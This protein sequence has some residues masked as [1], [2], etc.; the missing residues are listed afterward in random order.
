MK[1]LPS[2][3][4][5]SLNRRRL[6]SFLFWDRDFVRVHNDQFLFSVFFGNSFVVFFGFSSILFFENKNR[7]KKRPKHAATTAT[8]A[9]TSASLR[10]LTSFVLSCCLLQSLAA[11]NSSWTTTRSRL[12]K[13]LPSWRKNFFPNF[14]SSSRMRVWAKERTERSCPKKA[15]RNI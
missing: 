4:W 15:L 2:Y 6:S 10:L 5:A 3:F 11:T 13:F 9:A 7:L 8:A 14:F 12:K 1:T